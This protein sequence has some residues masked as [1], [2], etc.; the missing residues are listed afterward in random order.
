[1]VAMSR[2]VF[3]ELISWTMMHHLNGLNV[4]KWEIRPIRDALEGS[5]SAILFY[6]GSV[7]PAFSGGDS[8]ESISSCITGM[9]GGMT[10][11][12][13]GGPGSSV[14]SESC[15]ARPSVG[16]RASRHEPLRCPCE[17]GRLLGT[18]SR[19]MGAHTQHS[20]MPRSILPVSPFV[21]LLGKFGDL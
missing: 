14:G 18:F 5:E 16:H 12:A 7:V 17:A 6:G 21:E 8:L 2:R 10:I 3:L 1:M 13:R 20:R 19:N 15:L 11:S 4:L 9:L